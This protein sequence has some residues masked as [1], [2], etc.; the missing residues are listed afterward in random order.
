MIGISERRKLGTQRSLRTDEAA[1]GNT[2]VRR[3]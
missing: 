1:V 2:L 3:Q